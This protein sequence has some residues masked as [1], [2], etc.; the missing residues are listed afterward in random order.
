VSDLTYNTF[1]D[2]LILEYE[3]LK[4]D[5]DIGNPNL[6]VPLTAEIVEQK[7]EVLLRT[8]ASQR[9]RR[10]FNAEAF[11]GLMLLRGVEAGAKDGYAEAFYARKLVV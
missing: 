4:I 9:D 2:H 10:W 7:I 3:I 1:R 8:F 5:G 11:R 6:Y